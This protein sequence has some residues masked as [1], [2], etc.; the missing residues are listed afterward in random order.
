MSIASDLF[1]SMKEGQITKVVLKLLPKYLLLITRP[2]LQFEI[3]GSK[4]GVINSKF[5]PGLQMHITG[6]AIQKDIKIGLQ[7]LTIKQ[8]II[9]KVTSGPFVCSSMLTIYPRKRRFHKPIS[10]TVPFQK[11]KIPKVGKA[12]S[13]NLQVLFSTSRMHAY[14]P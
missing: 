14:F 3:T 13:Q 7:I 6:G 8:T 10:I 2:F 5:E 11:G 12:I 4:G 1:K 9:S